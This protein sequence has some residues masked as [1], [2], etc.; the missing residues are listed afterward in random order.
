MPFPVGI[1][2]Y[3]LHHGLHRWQPGKAPI[4][5]LY[6]DWD[7]FMVGGGQA[8]W[9]LTDGRKL[10]GSAGDFIILPP[11]TPAMVSESIAP[12]SFYYLHIAFRSV[13]VLLKSEAAK[14]CQGPGAEVLLPLM[15][16][17]RDAPAI[18]RSYRRLGVASK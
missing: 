13:S 17:A 11:F 4:L 18:G 14:N 6:H 3:S 5:L 15:I 10:V 2:T 16:S 7:V 8:T 1:P 9:T 12:M